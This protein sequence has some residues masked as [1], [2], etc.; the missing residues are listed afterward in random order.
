MKPLHPYFGGLLK[1][2]LLQTASATDTIWQ[3]YFF[4]ANPQT[5]TLSP[6]LAKA[7]K[8]CPHGDYKSRG[9]LVCEHYQP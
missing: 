5:R 8:L 9:A 4:L 6:I 3:S 2:L 7:I 1:F